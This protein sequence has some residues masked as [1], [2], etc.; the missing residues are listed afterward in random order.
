MTCEA[1]FSFLRRKARHSR[2][3]IGA[4][5]SLLVWRRPRAVEVDARMTLQ[6]SLMSSKRDSWNTPKVVLDFVSMLG[7]IG[8][9][10]CS[11]ADSIVRAGAA[12]IGGGLT[13][14]WHVEPGDGLIYVNPPYGRGIGKWID[15]CDQYGDAY[16]IIALLP[17]RTDAKWFIKVWSA[18]DLCFWR[19]RLR[20]LGAPSSAPFPSVVAYWGPRK[21][22]FA[23]IFEEVG[24]VVIP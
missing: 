10:P 6:R 1:C 11:N 24:H 19:G 5:P 17:A 23:A 22:Q 3:A 13:T 2:S 18:D 21:Y 4:V 16:E 7:P 14:P 20:F 8:L 9:D 15:L 12:F